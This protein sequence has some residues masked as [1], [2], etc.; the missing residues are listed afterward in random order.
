MFRLALER[1]GR[2][3]AYHA[4]ADEGVP[5]RLMTEAIGR[6]SGLP[7]RSLT[8]DEAAAHF[9]PLAVFVAGNGPASSERTRAALGWTP[10]EPGL[11]ADIDRPD[12][13]G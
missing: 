7:V 9:G 12:Y 11:L 2:G 3:E 1:A 5:Y 10:T 13:L 8:P 6:Q 4:V